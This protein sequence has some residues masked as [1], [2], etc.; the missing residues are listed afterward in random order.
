[1]IERIKTGLKS[2]ISLMFGA[3]GTRPAADPPAPGAV[4]IAGRN[5]PVYI[6]KNLHP[7]FKQNRAPIHYRVFIL[8]VPKSGTYLVAKLLDNLG[9]VDCGVHIATDFIQDNRFAD[10]NV[11]KREA[12]RYHVP[13]PFKISTKLIKNGQF[14]FGHIPYYLEGEQMLH[15]FKKIFTFRELRDTI[16][17]LVRYYDSRQHNY[18][19]PERIRLYNKFKEAPIGNPKFE[20]WYA[21]WGKEFA[22]LIRNMFPWKDRGDVYRVKFETLMGD[23][24]KEAQFSML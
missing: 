17:S 22:D 6:D 23:D 13:I 7:C 18:A 3:G 1:M 15:G 4:I 14:A 21:M 10:E 5:L 2:A 8:T 20:A 11:L 19:K 12:W 24:G 9:V 16:I